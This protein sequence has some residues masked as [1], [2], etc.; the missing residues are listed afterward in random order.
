MKNSTLAPV[1]PTAIVP[2]VRGLAYVDALYAEE[3]RGELPSE[4]EVYRSV[5]QDARSMGCRIYWRVFFAR[6]TCSA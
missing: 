3:L 2:V 6:N 5:P 4:D 1:A